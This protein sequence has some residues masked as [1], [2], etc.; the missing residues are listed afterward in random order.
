MPS[1]SP[2]GLVRNVVNSSVKTT[3][4]AASA[5]PHASQPTERDRAPTRRAA[6]VRSRQTSDARKNVPARRP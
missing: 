1:Q 3:A 4:N 5:H 6:A 2:A